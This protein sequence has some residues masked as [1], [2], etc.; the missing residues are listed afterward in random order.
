[1]VRDC[2]GAACGVGVYTRGG[3]FKGV[4]KAF[5]PE[6]SIKKYKSGVG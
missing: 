2:I 5:I 3:L 1:M 4:V 6:Q